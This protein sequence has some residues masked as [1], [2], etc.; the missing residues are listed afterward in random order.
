MR[1]ALAAAAAAGGCLA[2]GSAP[3]PD[4]REQAYRANNRGVALLEQFKA[5]D[6][7]A[8]FREALTLAPDLA[9]A[10]VN[11]AIA[12]L[13]APDLPGADKEARAALAAGPGSLQAQFVL[14]LRAPRARPRGR[15]QGRLPRGDRAR[16]VGRGRAASNLGQ[17]LMAG[18]R[19][20]GGDRGLPVGARDA[21]RTTR[22]RP[23]T[24][25]WR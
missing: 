12:L 20:P 23:T 4:A 17:M 18:A 8:A 14:G 9:L 5:Q 6:A 13:N 7:V 21:S 3:K 22:P 15:R 19:V 10:R 25:A 1:R 11:L 16:P 2:A 24:S